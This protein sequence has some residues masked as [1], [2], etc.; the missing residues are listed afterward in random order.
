MK[1]RS[2]ESLSSIGERF[3]DHRNSGGGSGGFVGSG[4]SGLSVG[5]CF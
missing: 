3:R 4:R 5:L 2:C 1:A